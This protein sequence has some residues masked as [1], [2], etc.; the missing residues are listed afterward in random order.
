MPAKELADRF[1]AVSGV[2]LQLPAG[3]A[4]Y[5]ADRVDPEL[6]F[7]ILADGPDVSARQAVAIQVCSDGASIQPD[8]TAIPGADPQLSGAACVQRLESAG[9]E[10][11]KIFPAEDSEAHSVEAR[12][13]PIRGYPEIA[14]PVLHSRTDRVHRQ[15]LFRLPN[16]G[17]VRRRIG[18]CVD[19]NDK[20]TGQ[21]TR[22]KSNR[23]PMLPLMPRQLPSCASRGDRQHEAPVEPD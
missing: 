2:D 3:T 15:T 13:S 7:G 9:L 17:D 8:E 19:G 4:R 6:A 23:H 22:G 12:E 1:S 20:K 16:R 5:A 10:T 18:L 14:L 21:E 11:R